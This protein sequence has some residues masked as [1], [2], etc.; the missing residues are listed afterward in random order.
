MNLVIV[1]Q[2]SP[3]GYSLAEFRHLVPTSIL[4]CKILQ[5][6]AFF[7]CTSPCSMLVPL[8]YVFLSRCTISMYNYSIP[9]L[10]FVIMVERLRAT[11]LVKHYEFEG[12]KFGIWL[13]LGVVSL[14]LQWFYIHLPVRHCFVSNGRCCFPSVVRLQLQLFPIAGRQQSHHKVQQFASH[15]FH[16]FS[17]FCGHVDR[18]GWLFDLQKEQRI[19]EKGCFE[20]KLV[21]WL[22][23]KPKV[24]P[25]MGSS[26]SSMVVSYNLSEKYQLQE[27]EKAMQLILPLDIAYMVAYVLYS[28]LV[29]V[30]R[31]YQPF[32]PFTT[33]LAHYNVIAYVGY[34]TRQFMITMFQ[35]QIL[36]LYTIASMSFYRRFLLTSI[37]GK[38]TN[39]KNITQV[40]PMD[41]I[42]HVY[43]EQLRAQWN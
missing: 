32:I 43:F 17:D 33:Y 8:W 7:S 18:I 34:Q 30:L 19:K 15:V 42:G 22:H 2:L 10:H 38:R 16:L 31:S 36:T 20:V 21:K 4:F 39:G 25:A 9:I 26:T 41:R 40:M 12:I 35:F 28:I 14:K 29:I 13:I 11:M 27:N 23:L 6:L 24:K 5:Y 1:Y 37:P 3:F